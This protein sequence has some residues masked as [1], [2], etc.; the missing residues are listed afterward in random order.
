MKNGR[1]SDAGRDEWA[2][3]GWV[4]NRWNQACRRRVGSIPHTLGA[5]SRFKPHY[6]RP[7]KWGVIHT[8][9]GLRLY[10]TGPQHSE[11][12]RQ[13]FCPS[14]SCRKRVHMRRNAGA[15]EACPQQ[16]DVRSSRS[17]RARKQKSRKPPA[18]APARILCV[19]GTGGR[20]RCMW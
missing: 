14:A 3:K 1:Y 5:S 20:I 7:Q 12:H 17:Q 18:S 9:I 16:H 4:L 2:E 15:T 8:L 11:R 19:N 6:A 10:K 13:R